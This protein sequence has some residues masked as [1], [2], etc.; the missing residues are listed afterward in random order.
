MPNGLLNLQKH[1]IVKK[2]DAFTGLLKIAFSLLDFN[3]KITH[4]FNYFFIGVREI[5]SLSSHLQQ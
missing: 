1:T 3:F 5:A 4:N 2:T